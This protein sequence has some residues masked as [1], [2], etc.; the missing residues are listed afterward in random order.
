MSGNTTNMS[1]N[2]IRYSFDYNFIYRCY[3]FCCPDKVF[4]SD[5]LAE[6]EAAATAQDL[7]A[8]GEELPTSEADEHQ[9]GNLGPSSQEIFSVH[10]ELSLSL[11]KSSLCWSVSFLITVSHIQNYSLEKV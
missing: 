3:K 9:C 4:E 10:T 8:A 7:Q 2:I 1:C 5:D 6:A 11:R